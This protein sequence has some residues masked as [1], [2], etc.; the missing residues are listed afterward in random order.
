M[1]FKEQ[2]QFIYAFTIIAA[3]GLLFF[4]FKPFL[5]NKIFAEQLNSNKIVVDSLMLEAMKME[6]DKSEESLFVKDSLIHK[7][8]T[9]IEDSS[10]ASLPDSEKKIAIPVK[11]NYRFIDV[12]DF[13]YNLIQEADSLGKYV[14]PKSKTL[15]TYNG[16]ENLERFFEKLYELEKSTEGNVRIAYYGDSMIDGDLIVQDFRSALQTRFGGRG[17]GFV[18]I[19]S[20]SARSRYSIKHYT[21]GNWNTKNFMKGRADS[22]PYGING[23]VHFSQDSTAGL[24]LLASG[25]KNSYRLNSPRLYYGKGNPNAAIQIKIDKDSL[26]QTIELNGTRSLNTATLSPKNSKRVE[27]DFSQ[28]QGLPIYGVDFSNDSGVHVDGFSKR[29]NSGLP[30]SLLHTAQ[31]KEFDKT[32]SYDLIILQFGANVLTRKSKNYSW[33]S[34]RMSKVVAHLKKSFPEA[35]I[36]ILGTADRGTKIG[37]LIKTDSSVVK[38]LRSQQIYAA[39][40]N[41]GFMSLF[42]LMGGENSASVWNDHK[43]MNNDYTHFSPQGSQKIGRMIYRELMND[44]DAFAKARSQQTEEIEKNLEKEPAALQVTDSLKVKNDSL[45]N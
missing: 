38:L 12:N 35:D 6:Q 24:K 30:L 27:L 20:E 39:N 4:L 41:S 14:L 37:D 13:N 21:S 11:S 16:K 2:K 28:A 19:T 32:L 44:Y 10:K 26:M 40:T 34:S 29:G 8:S 22:I 1:S 23:A 43:Y 42:H 18:P 36:L 45:Q 33:Y 15:T 31:M 7:K 25:I 5:P 9:I 3:G 17:V